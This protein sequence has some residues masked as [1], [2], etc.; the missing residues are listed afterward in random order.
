LSTVPET[1]DDERLWSNI[2]DARAKNFDQFHQVRTILL[3][4]GDFDQGQVALEKRA[5]GNILR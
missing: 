3:I 2:N 1:S 5:S 4:G